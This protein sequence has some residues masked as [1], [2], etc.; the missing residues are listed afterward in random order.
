MFIRMYIRRYFI[1]YLC[2]C[3]GEKSQRASVVFV[4]F[5]SGHVYGYSMSGQTIFSKQVHEDPISQFTFM[6]PSFSKRHES[7]VSHYNC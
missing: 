4:G 5:S 7:L 6:I 1:M 2:A 3:R